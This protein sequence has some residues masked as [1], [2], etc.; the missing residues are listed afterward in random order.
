MQHAE[1]KQNRQ[2]PKNICMQHMSK[3]SKKG[4]KAIMG[5][6]KKRLEEKINWYKFATTKKKFNKRLIK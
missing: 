5:K 1:A 4:E 6:N 3:T 2:R